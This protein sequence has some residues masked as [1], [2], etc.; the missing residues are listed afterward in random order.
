LPEFPAPF[1]L[2]EGATGLVLLFIALV[3]PERRNP[4]ME[5]AGAGGGIEEAKV[6]ELDVPPALA[7]ATPELELPPAPVPAP[8]ENPLTPARAAPAATAP[9]RTKVNAVDPT[10]PEIIRLAINGTRA[11]ARA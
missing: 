11:I 9:A 8:A 7:P 6:P 5:E 4:A 10:S 2:G 3:I 1:V